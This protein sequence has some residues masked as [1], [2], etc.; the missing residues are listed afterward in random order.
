MILNYN[1]MRYIYGAVMW[2]RVLPIFALTLAL[3]AVSYASEEQTCKTWFSR[4]VHRG[5]AFQTEATHAIVATQAMGGCTAENETYHGAGIDFSVS[6]GQRV[7]I[8]LRSI[9]YPEA[10]EAL[11][12][13]LM[14]RAESPLSAEDRAFAIAQLLPLME[15]AANEDDEDLREQLLGKA[16]GLWKD[17]LLSSLKPIPSPAQ[18]TTNLGK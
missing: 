5:S 13:L 2:N 6:G 17:H 15:V 18:L 10:A 4:K 16:R 3:G 11:E 7:A 12:P 8:T 9:D 14:D 1:A